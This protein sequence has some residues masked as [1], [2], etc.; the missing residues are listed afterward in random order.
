VRRLVLGLTLAAAAG[1]ATKQAAPPPA[2]PV[3]VVDLQPARDAL[4]LARSA[5]A[6][7]RAPESF[8]RAQGHLNE[9]EA[10][11]ADLASPDKRRQSEWLGR[12][13][14]VEAQCAAQIALQQE[15]QTDQRSLSTQEAERRN[16]KIR[17]QEDEQRRLE[18]QVALLKRELDFTE[19]EVI[20]TKS[21]LKG[22][23]TKAE[24]SS[25]IAE[26]RILLVRMTEERGSRA[27]DVQRAE[28]ALQRAEALLREENFGAA[29]FFAQKA[30]DAALKARDQRPV[31]S[32]PERPA[33]SASYT[34]KAATANLRKGPGTSEAIVARVPKGERLRA[35]VMR[36][37]W[38][39]VE[40]AGAT[41]WIHRS[42]V[43]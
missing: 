37:D 42:L 14:T 10:L 1:C 38:I 19:T 16:E 13:A 33:P 26:G 17:K 31:P 27:Q 7:E 36:G 28:Q 18:E 2:A 3:P 15:Q 9:A 29:I 5:G 21:R 25:A 4:E 35:S 23:E 39:R 32:E 12:L 11:A 41:G 8:G 40:H 22:I 6:D 43:E 30:Q 20:R 24:A 34:V